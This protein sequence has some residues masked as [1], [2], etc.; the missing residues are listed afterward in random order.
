M[1]KYQFK[2]GEDALYQFGPCKVLELGDEVDGH[3]P[4][5]AFEYG[6]THFSSKNCE[7]H[8]VPVTPDNSRH[9]EEFSRVFKNELS[10]AMVDITLH[11]YLISEWLKVCN[12][13]NSERAEERK[14]TCFQKARE[15]VAKEN[16]LGREAEELL[17]ASRDET[18]P[19]RAATVR[20]SVDR[21]K[22]APADVASELTQLIV[23]ERT[24]RR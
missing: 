14:A 16:A 9:A 12:E 5:V 3:R 23:S 4:V 19:Q 20:E 13:G 21:S 18:V 10:G 7:E 8:I 6:N 22:G 11:R 1:D 24:D 2:A 15:I 17:R